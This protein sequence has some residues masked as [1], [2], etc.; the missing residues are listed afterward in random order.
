VGRVDT[1]KGPL[2]LVADDDAVYLS[3][4][5]R[6]LTDLGVDNFM[7]VQDPHE[8]EEILKS[9]PCKLFISDVIMPEING[10]ELA[11]IANELQPGCTVILTTAYGTNLYRFAL[12]NHKFHLL[13]KPYNDLNELKK[14]LEHLLAGDEK[15]DDISEDSCSE[16]EDYP[17]LMEWKL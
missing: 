6:I 13:H 10:Y 14:F 5:R 17:H 15:F 9:T 3:F 2:T 4:W 16:N 12:E 1:K 8:A 7:L 11:K